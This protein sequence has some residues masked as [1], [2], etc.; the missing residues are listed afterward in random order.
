MSALLQADDVG[1]RNDDKLN[2]TATTC[3]TGLEFHCFEHGSHGRLTDALDGTAY[4]EPG[5]VLRRAA[6]GRADKEDD[7]DRIENGFAASY[8]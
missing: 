4:D 3:Q 6:K 2:D 7:D 8:V 1:Y 5:H